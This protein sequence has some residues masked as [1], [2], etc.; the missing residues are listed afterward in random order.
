MP[1]HRFK[2]GEMVV[3]H[4]PAIPPGPYTIIRLLPLIRNEP[5]YQGRSANGVVRAFLENQIKAVPEDTS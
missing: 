1:N 3:A 4:A 2:I 5:H